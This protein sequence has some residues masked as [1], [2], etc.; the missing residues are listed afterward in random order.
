MPR[1]P[2][3]V[4]L[5]H[6][7]KRGTTHR[8]ER[9]RSMCCGSG[10]LD[11]DRMF[12]SWS[13]YLCGSDCEHPRLL[14][15]RHRAPT[16]FPPPSTFRRT[17]TFFVACALLAKVDYDERWGA[18]AKLVA[19]PIRKVVFNAQAR[20]LCLLTGQLRSDIPPTCAKGIVP[21]Y[22][23]IHASFA[24]TAMVLGFSLGG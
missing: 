24:A 17:L 9:V 19:M 8:R 14:A 21:L 2:P 11:P 7:T 5:V 23:R 10:P 15:L 16:R 22:Y 20:P 13:C 4:Y 12:L 3:T 18:L 6:C 1:H